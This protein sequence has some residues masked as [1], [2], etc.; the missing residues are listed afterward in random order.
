MQV[1]RFSL[2]LLASLALGLAGAGCSTDSTTNPT[3]SFTQQDADDAAVQA[4][5]ALANL[6]A[7]IGG[8]ALD[9]GSS[10]STGSTLR[11]QSR[12]PG[13]GVRTDT[14]W[15]EGALVVTLSRRWFSLAGIEQDTPDETTDSVRVTSRIA[16]SDSTERYAVTVGHAGASSIGG[17]NPA[18]DELWI[19]IVQ[20]DTLVSRFEALHRPVT[21]WFEGR[22]TTIANDVRWIKPTTV[23]TYPA[24]G[25]LVMTLAAVAYRDGARI[26][27]E[28][29]WNALIVVRFNGTRYPNVVINGSWHYVWDVETGLIIRAGSA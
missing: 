19:D 18:R 12:H 9:G 1:R 6:G 24:S 3:T 25:T 16:G 21:R 14:T 13:L 20:A 27:V 17:L 28:K 7:V 26:D 23:P 22:T 15:T 2:P 10:A 8:A 5:I 29:S 4:S 11:L